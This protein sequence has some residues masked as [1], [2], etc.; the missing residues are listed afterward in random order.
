MPHQLSNRAASGSGEPACHS[1]GFHYQLAKSLRDIN[2][3]EEDQRFQTVA[4]AAKGL[5]DVYGLMDRR[6]CMLEL[7]T[8]IAARWQGMLPV[9]NSLSKQRSDIVKLKDELKQT[10]RGKTHAEN[11]ARQAIETS[12]R[13]MPVL[14]KTKEDLAQTQQELGALKRVTEEYKVELQKQREEVGGLRTRLH[15]LKAQE[16]KQK[17]EIKRLREENRETS[18]F[19]QFVAE[20]Q[21]QAEQDTQDSLDVQL[22]SESDDV[23]L[24]F[25]TSDVDSSRHPAFEPT[26]SRK[27]RRPEADECLPTFASETVI[28]SPRPSPRRPARR[29]PLAVKPPIFSSD[30]NLP[31]PPAKQR[32]PASRSGAESLGDVGFPINL[33]EKVAIR[34]NI[35]AL[36]HNI[37]HQQAQLAAL[38]N[39]VLRGP[40]PYPPGIFNSP[41]H[42]PAELD[43]SVPQ[44][45]SSSDSAYSPRA[46][47]I[48]RRSSFEALQGLAGPDS[49]LPLP[50]RNNMSFGDENGIRE[51][52]PTGSGSGQRSD[53]PTRTL[54]R[55]PVSSVGNAR[56]LAEE[57]GDSTL[58]SS[59]SVSTTSAGGVSPRRASFAPG[60]TTK[61]LAD[62]QAGVLN[63]KNA[64]E[65]TKAQ[66]RVSQRQVS[67]LTRQTE[68]LKEVRERL[69]L[70][71]EGLNNVV[72]RK[73]RLLQEVLERA[74]KAEAE[75]ISLKSQLKNETT[76]SKKTIRDMESSLTECT[77]RTQK[78]EREY[79]VL[80]DSIKGL[81]ESFQTDALTLREEVK[82]REDKLKA[83]AEEMGKKYK[84]LL[85][86]VQKE[87]E[88]GG[89]GEIK[90]LLYE[91]KRLTE[92]METVLKEEMGELRSEVD[93]HA[94]ESDEAN[95]TAK[96]LAAELGRLRRLMRQA[97]AV[98]AAEAR[99]S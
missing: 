84:R 96:T 48:A 26:T 77:A 44:R 2:Q 34:Q 45:P 31:Q 87:R 63:A 7:L 76:T 56:A 79:A 13:T 73:E 62:L 80:R 18:R 21:A 33:D 58:R 17:E 25:L 42:S 90:W 74:R 98:A 35:S 52:I 61:V 55:I 82:R 39:T 70:E 59:L 30:W 29:E 1:D 93:R 37:R 28:Y 49:S 57:D 78:A 67:Q 9:F 64:L 23:G 51:G 4:R 50:R 53:S 91:N 97:G 69:R 47:K 32:K 95:Q 81:V 14:T 24:E 6:D 20:S 12:E 11:V 3:V 43:L 8:A 15:A 19:L 65:N 75:V 27:R 54:S 92:Q 88:S 85:E 10:Q 86:Q 68:D 99:K 5:E 36:K 46:I 71:N 60:N 22:S 66:L 16:R 72:A 40:R 83:D 94:Q 41:P 38:E 89:L